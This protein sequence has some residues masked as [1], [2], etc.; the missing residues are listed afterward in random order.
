MV[1]GLNI[2]SIEAVLIACQIECHTGY[3]QSGTRARRSEQQ[4]L[5]YRADF[6]AIIA[7][8]VSSDYVISVFVQHVGPGLNL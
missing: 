2:K 8:V 3:M 1:D 7:A 6:I 4:W 5:C